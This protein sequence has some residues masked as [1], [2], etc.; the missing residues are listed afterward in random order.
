M[1]FAEVLFYKNI[2]LV[3]FAE[4]YRV[5][6]VY[7]ANQLPVRGGVAQIGRPIGDNHFNVFI[8]ADGVGQL[9]RGAYIDGSVVRVLMYFEVLAAHQFGILQGQV[10]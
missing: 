10:A 4:V 3:G 7:F 2:V 9:A 5:V 6:V 8:T 1:L